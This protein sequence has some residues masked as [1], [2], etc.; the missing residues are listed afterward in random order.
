[1]HLGSR[2]TSIALFALTATLSGCGDDGHGTGFP[3]GVPSV[4][5]DIDGTLTPTNLD[6][7]DA[8]P[9]AARAVQTFVDKGYAVIY[10]TARP[11]FLEDFTRNWLATH[12][13]PNLPLYLST[14]EQSGDAAAYKTELLSRLER[15]E[16]RVF[17]YA[18]GDSSTDFTAYNAVGVPIPE[19]WA[20]LRTNEST[21]QPGE[22]AA[23]LAGYTEHLAYIEA[24]PNVR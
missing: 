10:A 14:L 5:F 16:D 17:V 24:Q 15:D 3:P 2:F 4:V 6:I 1:M 21:C 23:C 12:G 7:F 9:D 8:R 20:L 18:Y 11:A 13:F 22:Y 19:T